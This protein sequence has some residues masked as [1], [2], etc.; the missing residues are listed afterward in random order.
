MSEG[1]TD[2]AST[3]GIGGVIGTNF[4]WPGAPGMAEKEEEAVADARAREQLWAKWTRLY[5]E[6]RLVRGEYLG[7]LYDIGFDSSRGPRR[8]Q[9]RL[10]LLRVLRAEFDGTVELRGLAARAYRLT[11]YVNGRDLGVVQ[12]PTAK[13]AAKF[14]QSLLIEARP[15]QTAAAAATNSTADTGQFHEDAA[16]QASRRRAP[17]STKAAPPVSSIHSC[18]TRPA[19]STRRMR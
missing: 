6:K 14:D 17:K 4:A 5:D 18:S 8:P 15:E 1:G 7:S 16:S 3:F 19:A 10:A 2:F 9:R 12:G 11:D 13:V